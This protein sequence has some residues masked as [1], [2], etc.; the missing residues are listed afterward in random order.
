[1]CIFNE[2]LLKDCN[3]LCYEL[4]YDYWLY[5]KSQSDAQV[6]KLIS[7]GYLLK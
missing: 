5:K 4:D 1:M 7:K 6:I 2:K 3:N